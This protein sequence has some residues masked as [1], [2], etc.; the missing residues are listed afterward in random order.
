[1][2][3]NSLTLEDVEDKYNSF[4]GIGSSLDSVEAINET[5]LK[6]VKKRANDI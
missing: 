6:L 4:L 5:V 3:A 1:M 2:E